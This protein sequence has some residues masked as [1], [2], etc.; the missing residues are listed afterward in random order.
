MLKHLSAL[1]TPAAAWCPVP[2]LVLVARRGLA[3][4]SAADVTNALRPFY[5]AVHP[6]FFGQHPR[7]RA[8]NES[9][10][11]RLNG[12]LE[13]LQRPDTRAPHPL[14]VTFYV[15][16]TQAP[17]AAISAGFTPVSFTLLSGDLVATVRDILSSCR[18]PTQ[19]LAGLNVRHSPA[20]DRPIKWDKTFYTFTGQKD[21]DEEMRKAKVAEPTLGAWLQRHGPTAAERLQK[22]LP[23]RT[24]VQR[25][26]QELCQRMGLQDIRWQRQWGV[27]HKN[28]Q[29]HSLSRMGQQFPQ[30]AQ[31][32]KGQTLLF[33]DQSGVNALGH[34]MLGTTDVH[35]HWIKAVEERPRLSMVLAQLRA[36][37]ERARRM[38]GGASLTQRDPHVSGLSAQRAL[39]RL[40]LMRES[41][42]R[43]PPLFLPGS[44]RDLRLILEGSECSL[45]LLESGVFEVPV[46]SSADALQ[47]FIAGN[48]R[49][50]R[51]RM[52]AT[53]RLEA[54]AL[55]LVKECAER[56]GAHRLR[57][58]AGLPPAALAECCRRLL[59]LPPPPTAPHLSGLRGMRVCVSRYYAVSQ[60]GEVVIPW[61]WRG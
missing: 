49:E 60:D 47:M 20:P 56:L 40:N 6:D 46:T 7:E 25:L 3:N 43:G 4:I 14:H 35:H 51:A 23:L 8:V 45:R 44:L 33:T 59:L 22:S 29:L 17:P 48:A 24:A 32:L 9:S 18:L 61:Q 16:T 15:R 39:A 2:R 10:L 26:K 36:A 30:L 42:L 41:A 19:H 1:S 21:P 31:Q 38:L 28:S 53:Q 55:A 12:Y 11:K 58:E 27:A 5:F 34:I 52:N 50:A 13:S 57:G 37:E 54:E